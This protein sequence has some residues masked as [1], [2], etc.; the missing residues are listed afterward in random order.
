MASKALQLGAM[1]PTC[2]PQ[3]GPRHTAAAATTIMAPALYL[4]ERE[5]ADLL[6]PGQQHDVKQLAALTVA[7]TNSDRA[8][9]AIANI[10]NKPLA[11]AVA[12]LS[13]ATSAACSS[14]CEETR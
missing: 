2:C 7:S 1:L 8:A 9:I 11:L 14:H 10:S 5:Q 12:S 6:V 4:D 13:R 3:S